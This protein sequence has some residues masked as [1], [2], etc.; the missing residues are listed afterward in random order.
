[1]QLKV[2]AGESDRLLRQVLSW[3]DVHVVAVR[4]G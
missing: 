4:E 1:M 3:D 2:A